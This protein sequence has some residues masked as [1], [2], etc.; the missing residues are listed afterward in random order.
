MARK[1]EKFWCDE[2]APPEDFSFFTL[3]YCSSEAF[4]FLRRHKNASFAETFALGESDVSGNN[5][6]SGDQPVS[7]FIDALYEKDEGEED[8]PAQKTNRLASFEKTRKL[9]EGYAPKLFYAVGDGENC[10]MMVDAFYCFVGE[11]FAGFFLY[12]QW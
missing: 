2:A 1:L 12:K 4:A 6:M 9:L 3:G 8:S 5:K 7:A 10:D 11:A